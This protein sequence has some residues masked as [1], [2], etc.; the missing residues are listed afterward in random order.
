MNM[1]QS[2]PATQRM[3]RVKLWQMLLRSVTACHVKSK[4]THT[5]T[6]RNKMSTGSQKI[7]LQKFIT[8]EFLTSKSSIK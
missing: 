1:Q 3:G 6:L 8:G 7:N 5:K 2:K 4:A